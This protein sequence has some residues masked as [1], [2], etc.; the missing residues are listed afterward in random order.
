MLTM[1]IGLIIAAIL[2]I[3]GTGQWFVQNKKRKNQKYT[4]E[5]ALKTAEIESRQK[6]EIG[7]ASCRERV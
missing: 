2:A 7:R 4:L 5:Y 6:E 3:A 1:K